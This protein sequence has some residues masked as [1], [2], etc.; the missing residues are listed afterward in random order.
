V[1]G[2][3]RQ[4]DKEGEEEK[5]DD[6]NGIFTKPLSLL[7]SLICSDGIGFMVFL[8]SEKSTFPPCLPYLFGIISLM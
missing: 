8:F 2:L 7:V 4:G 1:T 6:S 5:N 3:R